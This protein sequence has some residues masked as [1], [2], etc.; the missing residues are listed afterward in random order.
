MFPQFSNRSNFTMPRNANTHTKTQVSH[1]QLNWFKIQFYSSILFRSC[2]QRHK[3][4]GW[5]GNETYYSE[6]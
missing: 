4:W 5:W 6:T 2:S 1:K 3:L